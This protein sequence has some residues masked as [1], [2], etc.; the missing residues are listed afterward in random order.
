MKK[1]KTKK[2]LESF[3]G[4]INHHKKY[5]YNYTTLTEDLYELLEKNKNMK[6]WNEHHD[7]KF[8]ECKQQILRNVQRTFQTS[9]KTLF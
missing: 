1:P 5:I 6:Q 8:E 4:T 2:E 3:L 9:I 7:K